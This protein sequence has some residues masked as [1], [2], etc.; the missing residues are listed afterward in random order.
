MENRIMKNFILWQNIPSIH[1]SA[2][3]RNLAYQN[4]AKVTLVTAGDVPVRRQKMGWHCPDFGKAELIIAPS[5]S[6]VDQLL[7]SEEKNTV[8]IFS[9]IRAYPFVRQVFRRACKTDAYISFIAEIPRYHGIKGILRK[10]VYTA[11]AYRY[12]RRIDCI[13]AIGRKAP[14]WFNS[15]G[16]P[17]IKIYP[18][19]YFIETPKMLKDEKLMER[20][21]ECCHI[22]FIG[23]LV[24]GKGVDLLLK[25]LAMLPE[26]V[27]WELTIVGD[28][29]E[30]IA[31]ERLRNTLGLSDFVSFSGSLPNVQAMEL[32]AHVDLLV[33][34]SRYDGWGAVVSESL[35]L[36]V[37][38]V[39]SDDCG[40]SVLLDGANR[41]SVFVSNSQ[42][43]LFEVLYKWISKG[44]LTDKMRESIKNWA[45][46]HI[47]GAV[48][49]KHLIEIFNHV[50]GDGDMPLTPW[51]IHD[52]KL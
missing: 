10:V 30:R 43:H 36:G 14:D 34:P 37:P 48:A 4:D 46:N 41:G 6:V 51:M 50:C 2:L 27:S 32:L 22:V 52:N 18:F 47:S 40:A 28:G 8:H 11:S 29:L 7:H 39:C 49:A 31:L 16:Y 44:P 12:R 33:L 3:I 25:S 17:A 23:S 19:A 13:F 45:N 1:Q 21:R 24:R 5:P 20:H 26:G 38:V 35:M 42:H 15:C 9:G